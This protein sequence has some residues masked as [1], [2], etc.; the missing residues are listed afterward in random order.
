APQANAGPDQTV[1]G[2]ASVTLDGTGSSD[3]DGEALTFAWS[4]TESG[5]TL[6]DPSSPKP[7]F[8]APAVSADTPLTFSLKVC[9]EPNPASLC[10]TDAVVV[11]V[12]APVDTGP[13]STG[14]SGSGT[15]TGTTTTATGQRAAALKRC[16]KKRG[17]A[18]ARCRRTAKRLPV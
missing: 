16:K 3:P 10:N 15:G 7:T 1:N 8:T 17:A 2:G 4:T 14:G 13:G 12:K 5:V 18:R 11:N 9:D 6:S